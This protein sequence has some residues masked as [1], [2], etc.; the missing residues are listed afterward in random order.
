MDV[1]YLETNWRN[2]LIYILT[3]TEVKNNKILFFWLKRLSLLLLSLDMYNNV[4]F[5]R[6]VIKY[7]T[8]GI[9]KKAE[10]SRNTKRDKSSFLE[11]AK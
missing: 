1:V 10:N 6:Q 5:L 9:K 8:S 3:H 11:R 2:G 4:C 7:T